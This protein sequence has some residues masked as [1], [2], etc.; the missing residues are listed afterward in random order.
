MRMRMVI[1]MMM[2]M[3][4]MMMIR[5]MIRM[6]MRI[7]MRMRMVLRMNMMVMWRV[8]IMV[9]MMMVIM[10]MI[11]RIPVD[12]KVPTTAIRMIIHMTAMEVVAILRI[13]IAETNSHCSAAN[14]KQCLC[15]GSRYVPYQAR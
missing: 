10:F 9:P 12:F 4:M 6:M 5:M 14:D 3:M 1:R 2:M 15:T 11:A 7:M 13:I 8:S